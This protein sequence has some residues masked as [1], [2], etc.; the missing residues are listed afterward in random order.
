MAACAE[1]LEQVMEW[2]G[3][4]WRLSQIRQGLIEIMGEDVSWE[5]TKR[6]VNFARQKIRVELGVDADEYRGRA[7]E[8]Y[9]SI[10]RSDRAGLKYKLHAQTR[11]DKLLGLEAVPEGNPNEYAENLRRAISMVDSGIPQSPDQIAEEEKPPEP[12][13]LDSGE[14]LVSLFST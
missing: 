1:V 9:A 7:V 5:L 10:I 11:L 6:V 4:Q 13:A 2:L 12:K 14:D 8:F 3:R